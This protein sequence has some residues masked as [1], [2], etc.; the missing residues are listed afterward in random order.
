MEQ[1]H[2][3]LAEKIYQ[4]NIK[5]YKESE[6]SETPA[7]LLLAYMNISGIGNAKGDKSRFLEN[8]KIADSLVSEFPVYLRTYLPIR[9]RGNA[10]FKTKNDALNDLTR[11][12]SIII[13]EGNNIDIEYIDSHIYY[14]KMFNQFIMPKSLWAVVDSLSLQQDDLQLKKVAILCQIYKNKSIGNDSKVAEWAIKYANLVPQI[15]SLNAMALIA[16]MAA[17]YQ[18]K[19]LTEQIRVNEADKLLEA[20]KAR[21]YLYFMLGLTLL[22]IILAVNLYFIYRNFKRNRLLMQEKD[23]VN[24]AR[25]RVLQHENLFLVQK[26][27]QTQVENEFERNRIAYAARL[28]SQ[29]NTMIESVERLIA[30]SDQETAAKLRNFKLQLISLRETNI[31]NDEVLKQNTD[32]QSDTEAYL[33][34]KIGELMA[35]MSSAEIQ[36]L[37][38][39]KEGFQIKDIAAQTGYSVSY[40]ENIRSGLRKKLNVPTE[41]KLQE[42]LMNL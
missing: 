26:N 11:L 3:D 12:D 2:Y 6:M 22:L 20:K 24:L 38:L 35:E 39:S 9:I 25:T 28:L 34:K 14:Y 33:R 16:D 5:L 10:M 18:L 13:A 8:M 17:Q 15:D 21:Q 4:E 27:K 32:L 30:G 40:V 36:I 19:E 31:Q 1:K 37:L 23:Q 29:L 41:V 42:Y 7:W